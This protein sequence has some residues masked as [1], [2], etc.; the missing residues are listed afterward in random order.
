MN[1][2]RIRASAALGAASALLLAAGCGGHRHRGAAEGPSGPP[3]LDERVRVNQIQVRGSHNSYHVAPIVPFHPSHRYTHA[4][5]DV[6]LGLQRV[7]ALE[8]DVHWSL[9]N[10][11]VQVYHLGLI[12]QTTTCFRFRDCLGLVA[13][14]SDAHPDH[15]PV[16][17]WIEAKDEFDRWKFE[18]LEPVDR[19]LRDVLGERLLAPDEVQGPYETLR[20]AIE[21]RGWPTLAEA[22]GRILA[23][24][25]NSGDEHARR[26]TRDFTT[27]AG[28]AMFA[29]AERDQ[30][31]A[32]W[33]AVSGAG[34]D[35]AADALALGLLL[36][37]N[38]C[39]ASETDE[40]CAAELADALASG[41][42]CLKDDFPAPVPGR[43][44][45]LDFPGGALARCN[46][47]TADGAC[48][49]GEALGEP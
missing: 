11:E 47:V 28:R 42:H 24:L 10:R 3:T 27:L 9:G 35:A 38:T 13:A 33:A 49:P 16:F 41:A 5:L 30:F 15:L 36:A 29:S 18:T 40:D 19:D 23:I 4:P 25:I 44:Y 14:W 1:S 6:Q 39:S 43:S 21:L 32:P 37:R 17:L 45:F 8:L 22:R 12:D 31:T 46:P 20:R 7:R 48:E 26:Y 34:G 2:R